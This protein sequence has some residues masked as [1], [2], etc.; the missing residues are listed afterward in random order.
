MALQAVKK[1]VIRKAKVKIVKDKSFTFIWEGSDRKGQKVTGH[2]TAPSQAMA[3][4]NLRKQGITPTKVKKK[5]AD[6]FAARK[7]PVTT[8]LRALLR[9]SGT[10]S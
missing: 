3:K 10:R 9:P 1:P 8:G 5:A 7:K 4:A 2:L 6:L